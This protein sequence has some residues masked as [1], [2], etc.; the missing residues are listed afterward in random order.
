MNRDVLVYRTDI[1]G[2]IYI[3][4][5]AKTKEQGDGSFSVRFRGTT[6]EANY[7][8][9]T[10]D[11]VQSPAL[12]P[13]PDEIDI[14][15]QEG[16][17]LIIA[18]PDFIGINADEAEL[19]SLED[20]KLAREQRGFSVVLA[21]L[22]QVYAQFGHGV[23]DAQA[24]KDYIAYAYQNMGTEMV[25]LVGGDTFD[26]HGNLGPGP[27]S[28]VP[29]LYAQTDPIVHFAPVDPKYADVDDD[30]LPDL[31]IGRFPVRSSA[32][33]S[34]MVHKTLVWDTG[35]RNTGENAY[36]QTALFIADGYDA[37]QKYDFKQDA[38]IMRALAPSEWQPV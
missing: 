37:A 20:L 9:V 21:D 26:Y 13:P 14:T 34:Q 35:E 31:A 29:S 11:A 33:L 6:A 22:E 23:V 7:L 30:N 32:E 16:K 19:Y 10:E 12:L 15:S 18:H 17:Y 3:I 25:L 5:R 36:G 4:S 38:E 27:V 24:I 8:V 2:S 28:F 1:D